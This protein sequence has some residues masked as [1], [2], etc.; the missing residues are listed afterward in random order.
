MNTY[1]I[2]KNK[3]Y[4]NR[5]PSNGATHCCFFNTSHFYQCEFLTL[6]IQTLT[7]NLIPTILKNSIMQRKKY[8]ADTF[9]LE[10]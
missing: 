1:G 4:Y 6:L 7:L 8:E 5:V 2:D 3:K 9:A 10:I